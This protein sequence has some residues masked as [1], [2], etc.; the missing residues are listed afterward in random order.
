[1]N[2]IRRFLLGSQNTI[3]RDAFIW[4]MIGGMLNACQS[5]ILLVV[6]SHVAPVQD[7][8]VFALAYAIASLAVSLGKYGMRTFQSSDVNEKYSFSTYVS[9]R[10]ITSIL[11]MALT[12]FYMIK[13]VFL[14]NYGYSKILAILLVGLM[15][16]IDTI[17]DVYHGRLQQRLRFDVAARCMAARYIGTMLVI[18]IALVVS[19]DLLISLLIGLLFTTVFYIYT[20]R[21]FNAFLDTEV[22]NYKVTKNTVH[23]LGECFS[24]A[25]GGFLA[26]Y[27]ANAPKYAIDAQLNETVQAGFNYIFM[28]VYIVSTLSSF[29]FQPLITRMAIYLDERR[30]DKIIKMFFTLLIAI[31]GLSIVILLAGYFWGIPVLTIMYNYDLSG[32]K[33]AFMVLLIGGVLLAYGSFFNVCVVIFRKQN[34]LLIGYLIPAIVEMVTANRV[35]AVYG[36]TGVAFLYTGLILIQ[37]LM[38]L[39]VLF[40]SC[41]KWNM[42]R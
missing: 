36:V 13:G 3:D 33:Y 8:G 26:I 38:F 4:N 16:L 19:H 25:A 41:Y 2:M 40:L 11:M 5:A 42:E 18:I 24:I 27:I 32:Y 12:V 21:V 10:I 23:L 39:I 20:C 1:M 35:V 34:W 31:T 28:P 6:I 37:T 14:L 29:I 22:R 9:S 17:E 7:A 15:K 30:K